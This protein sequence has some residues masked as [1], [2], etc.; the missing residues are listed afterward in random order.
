MAIRS[1]LTPKTKK[2]IKKIKKTDI[3][4]GIPSFNN[5]A[6][7]GYVIET[8][9]LGLAKYFPKFR[10]VIVNSDCG[11]TDKTR[12]AAKT[13]L[14]KPSP[15]SSILIQHEVHPVTLGV[16]IPQAE[17][18]SVFRT[19]P[20]KGN[21]FRRIFEIAHRLGA[22]VCVVVDSDL[23]SITPEW[24]QLLAGP[25]LYKNYDYVA[26]LYV[27]HKYDA[28]ITNS[29]IY[30]LIRALYCLK[31]RQPIGGEFGFS[32]RLLKEYISRDVWDT[33]IA[34]YGIDIWMTT[35]AITSGFKIC[36]SFL[37]AKIH[38]PKEPGTLSPMFK[39]VIGTVFALMEDY[40][41]IWKLKTQKPQDVDTYGY[42]Y[43]V[44]P[45]EVKIDTELSWKKFQEGF[46]LYRDSYQQ[47]LSKEA[48]GFLSP[49]SKSQK[50]L[51][52]PPKIW[53]RIVYDYALGYH[54]LASSRNLIL[55]S[56][57]PLYHGYVFSFATISRDEDNNQAEERI[58]NLA[59]EFEKQKPY[60][61]KNWK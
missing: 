18:L 29:I 5:E 4:V 57:V 60:L 11:S 52:I 47:I 17:I 51:V 26:P 45:E 34:F 48:Y 37:G 6:T 46:T 22:Q 43:T 12:Q 2:E 58:E 38:N 24:I 49:L 28:T 53:T 21:A 19:T 27:R 23:R 7:I 44:I 10:T 1:I 39:Q 8:V 36:Q 50:G 3:L 59:L 42:P 9:K 54:N 31:L 14:K 25:I 30:P 32:K 13:A 35:L 56:L 41:P 33:D 61:I 16:N 20:G 40:S 55:E 15:I